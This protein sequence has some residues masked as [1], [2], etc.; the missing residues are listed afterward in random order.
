MTKIHSECACF[1]IVTSP[2]VITLNHIEKLSIKWGWK[3]QFYLFLIKWKYVRCGVAVDSSKEYRWNICSF[4]SKLY[5]CW[6][7]FV[8]NLCILG[9]NHTLKWSNSLWLK[10]PTKLINFKFTSRSLYAFHIFFFIPFSSI[11]IVG[12]PSCGL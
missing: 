4:L 11:F 3:I 1:P 5:S 12:H 7:S 6:F 10:I 9:E 8:Q 2:V